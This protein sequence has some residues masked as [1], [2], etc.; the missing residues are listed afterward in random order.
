MYT[1]AMITD[2]K[3]TP[4]WDLASATAWATKH[5]LSPRSVV[6]KVGALGLKYNSKTSTA[7]AA[8]P[9]APRVNKADLVNAINT[10][11]N[12]KAASLDKVNMADLALILTRVKEIL[13][14]V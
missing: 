14:D 6:S 13:T 3:A 11:L 4:V 8:K 12:I 2:L 10:K 5:G 9:T 1:E 7:S